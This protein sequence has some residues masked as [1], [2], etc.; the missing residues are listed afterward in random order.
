SLWQSWGIQPGAVMGHSLGEYAAACVAGMFS[1]EEGL[2]L[3]AERGRLMD[4]IPAQGE[5]AVVFANL[6][7][8]QAA[9]DPYADQIAIAAIN[10]PDTVVISGAQPAMNAVL[11]RLKTQGIRSRRLAVSQASHSPLVEPVL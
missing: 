4:S 2:G 11:E 1:L 9:I 10:G 8:V 3:V 7:P 6:E 5:M